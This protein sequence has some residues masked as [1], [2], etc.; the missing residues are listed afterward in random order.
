MLDLSEACQE[1]QNILRDS[2]G[3]VLPSL[4][5]DK[6]LG[7]PPLVMLKLDSP[8][9]PQI[10]PQNRQEAVE[11]TT[12][13]VKSP[14]HDLRGSNGGLPAVFLP[15]PSVRRPD[16]VSGQ[17]PPTPIL[18]PPLR[19]HNPHPL[20]SPFTN[21]KLKEGAELGLLSVSPPL[22]DDED[23]RTR[24]ERVKRVDLFA[25]TEGHLNQEC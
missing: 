12:L 16:S 1:I 6:R 20:N 19:S 4:P 8:F 21:H 15:K 2:P 23:R 11:K 14:R 13:A 7:T 24:R 25:N 18:T 3:E 17:L 5:S 22:P 9:E 10:N